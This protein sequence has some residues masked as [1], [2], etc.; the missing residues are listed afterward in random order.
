M[1]RKHYA[2]GLAAAHNHIFKTLIMPRH[3]QAGHSAWLNLMTSNFP[4]ARLSNP[5]APD[6]EVSSTPFQ[7]V[8]KEAGGEK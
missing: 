1:A 5:A 7:Q 3:A 8:T 6:E 2:S 4:N